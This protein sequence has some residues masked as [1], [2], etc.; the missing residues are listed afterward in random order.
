MTA[1]ELAAYVGRV[2]L[3][4]ASGLDVEVTVLDA[5][6]VFNRVDLLVT[7]VQ[8]GRSNWV[9]AERVRQQ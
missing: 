5:R 4:R 6:R 9:S 7:P 2:V 1:R 3:L 8:G